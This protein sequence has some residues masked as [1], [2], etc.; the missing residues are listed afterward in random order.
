MSADSPDTT[1]SNVITAEFVRLYSESA[2]RIYAYIF[3]MVPNEDAANDIFQDVGAALWESFNQFEAGT[4]FYAWARQIAHFRVLRYR[5]QQKRDGLFLADSVLEVLAASPARSPDEISERQRALVDCTEKLNPQDRDLLN[6]RYAADQ[7]TEQ[8]ATELSLSVHQV[9]RSLR[10][11]H[12]WLFECV[13]R[14]LAQ[15]ERS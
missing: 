5:D 11:I 10:R 3:V 14:A 15:E 13:R 2:R 4:S 7:P 9:Y 1:G 12:V 8:I 6:R